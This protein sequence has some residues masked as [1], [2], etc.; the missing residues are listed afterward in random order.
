MPTISLQATLNKLDVLSIH[1]PVNTP[2]ITE[3]THMKQ[4][5][6]KAEN[7]TCVYSYTEMKC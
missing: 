6:K 7:K 3:R 1:L 2:S 5:G 4:Y